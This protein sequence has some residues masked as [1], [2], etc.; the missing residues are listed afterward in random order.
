MI[1]IF[2]D[3]YPDELL[4][5]VCA[6]Y[7]D[8]MQYPNSTTATRDFYG[9]GTI[10][11]VVGLPNKIDYLVS[12]LPPGHLYTAEYFIDNHT[13]FP[14]YAPFLSC[15]RVQL[16][17]DG[18]RRV[19]E[20][21]VNE[22]IGLTAS[23]IP[24]LLWLRFCPKCAEADKNLFGETYW[25]RIHQVS[26][27]EVCPHHAAFLETS[28][29]PFHN[30]RN[31]GEAIS[32][33][34]VLHNPP[35]RP[36]NSSDSHHSML[37][38]I[39]RNA[40]WLLEWEKGIRGSNHLRERYYNR[41]LSRGLAY[42]NG[43]IRAK[44]L[45]NQFSEH[46]P[47]RILES[48][49]CEIKNPHNNWL[50]RLLRSGL[51]EV[52]QHPIRH[53]LLILFLGYTTEEFCT[54]FERYKPFGDGPWPCLNHTAMHFRQS[55]LTDC[56]IT[57]NLVKRKTGRPM[58]I[59]KC[60]CGFVY[61]RVGPDRSEDDRYRID[62]IES[63]GVVWEKVL[64]EIWLDT[65]ITLREASRRLGVSELTVVRYAIR[66]E[67]PMNAPG[68]RP[69]GSKT[70]ARYKSFRRSRAEA[71]EFYRQEWLSLLEANP[72]T[73]RRQLMTISSFL[74][75][76]LRKNDSE[77]LE[78]HLPPVRKGD[79]K[80]E[81]KDWK[82]IDIELAAAI[83]ATAKRIREMPGC[84]ARVSMAA[85]AKEVSH[86]PWLEQHLNKLPLTSKAL[87]DCLE[88]VEEFLLRRVRWAE[89]WYYERGICPARS[90]F[91]ARAGV[92]NKTGEMP[93]V[94][95]AVDAAMERLS[96]RLNSVA[97]VSSQ[98]NAREA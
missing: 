24:Q 85:I 51:A 30:T 52:S 44:E 78:D 75:L 76:W 40:A 16:V 13:L 71:L 10:S 31:P 93:A 86:K 47:P 64:R 41:L 95:R 87:K 7:N 90:Y 23:S 66:L 38:A 82:S 79:R 89:E 77:W 58:G 83:G 18:M 8:L 69:V 73:S 35:V 57:D 94:Q 72:S 39:A 84:P 15:N 27:V 20:N 11:A 36:L 67:L 26:G 60:E 50:L 3:P 98:L 37:L 48:L 63:Y 65:S 91:K 4:Y 21:Q 62:S 88:S 28:A 49:N 61:N 17:R 55:V 54:S 97:A 19:G 29:A 34:S 2:P 12:K 92:K 53:I 33:E 9:D 81:L 56:R 74:Y 68:T 59:F 25:H 5:S 42:Y 46:Y 1:C 32:A 22:Q 70:L 43:N 80:T 96:Q 6:R 45:A 14:F